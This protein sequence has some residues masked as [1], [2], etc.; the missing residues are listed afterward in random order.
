[1]PIETSFAEK[2]AGSQNCDDGF[3]AMLGKDGELDLAFLDVKTA[4]ATCPCEK[5]I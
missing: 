1:M 3:F 5:I 4:S 2:V